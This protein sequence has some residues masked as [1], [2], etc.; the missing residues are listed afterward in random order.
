MCI[1]IFF[2]KFKS[3]YYERPFTHS[4]CWE[5]VVEMFNIIVMF[6]CGLPFQKKAVNR[7]GGEN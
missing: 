5:H 3:S 6:L 2:G 7:L 1:E 4:V